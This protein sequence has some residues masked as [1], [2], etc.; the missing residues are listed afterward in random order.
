[1]GFYF[2]FGLLVVCILVLVRK[3]GRGLDAG[4]KDGWKNQKGEEGRDG[5]GWAER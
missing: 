1:M 3:G 4:M 2:G 5:S